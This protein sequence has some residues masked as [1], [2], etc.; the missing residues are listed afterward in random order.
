MLFKMA[1]FGMGIWGVGVSKRSEIVE[2]EEV[3]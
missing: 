1:G 2:D 3:K